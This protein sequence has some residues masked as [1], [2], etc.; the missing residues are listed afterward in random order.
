MNGRSEFAM[1]L[2]PVR[3]WSDRFFLVSPPSFASLKLQ[4]MGHNTCQLGEPELYSGLFPQIWG[5]I[6]TPN[7]V[8]NE[9]DQHNDGTTILLNLPWTTL[10]MNAGF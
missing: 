2:H 5:K 8:T 3:K 1:T 6:L 10:E 7:L 9:D 4:F